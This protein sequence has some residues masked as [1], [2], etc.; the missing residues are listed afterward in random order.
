[1]GRRK[2]LATILA[3][4]LAVSALLAGCGS[5]SGG[6]GSTGQ[7]AAQ[8]AHIN[9]ALYWFGTSL[10]PAT[11]YD[12]WTT[13]RAGITETLVTVDKNYEIQDRKSVV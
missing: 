13:C 6:E 4:T 5:S 7:A 8:D 9:A 3:M 1:M 10:D 12:G 2:I 11:E